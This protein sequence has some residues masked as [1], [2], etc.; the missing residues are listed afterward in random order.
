MTSL[1]DTYR[2]KILG[3]GDLPR[4]SYPLSSLSVATVIWFCGTVALRAMENKNTDII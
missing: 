3:V 4:P 2:W 1:V